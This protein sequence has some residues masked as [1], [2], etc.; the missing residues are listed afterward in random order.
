MEFG[1]DQGLWGFGNL[2]TTDFFQ[3]IIVRDDS[4]CQ[5]LRAKIGKRTGMVMS[6]KAHICR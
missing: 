5:A 6:V 1:A 3:V 4:A 2:Q